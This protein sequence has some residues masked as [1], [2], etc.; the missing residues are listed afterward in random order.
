MT[1]KPL[2]HDPHEETDCEA[3]VP[4][5]DDGWISQLGEEALAPGRYEIVVQDPD[6]HRIETEF[7]LRKDRG[8]K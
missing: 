1:V 3:D 5:T 8:S 4:R 2:D 7:V 6:G